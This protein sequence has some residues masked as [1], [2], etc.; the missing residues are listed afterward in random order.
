MKK[1]PGEGPIKA[2]YAVV[3]EAPGGDEEA[4]GR[5][6]VGPAGRLLDALLRNAGI[7]RA[8]CWVTNVCKY[9]PPENKIEKWI[10]KRKKPKKGDTTLVAERAGRWYTAQVAEGLFEL[11]REL[12]E[13]QPEKIIAFGNAALWALTGEWGIGNWRGSE[14]EYEGV[15]ARP[16]IP[17]YHPAAVLRQMDLKFEVQHDL[18]A[19][20]MKASHAPPRWKFETELAPDEI[21]ARL[22]ALPEVVAVDCEMSH[23]DIILIQIATSPCDAFCVQF[24]D[25]NGKPFWPREAETDLK[26]ALARTLRERFI[27]GQNFVMWDSW[28]IANC[29]GEEVAC[30]FDTQVAQHVLM[31]GK[32]K[33]L[34]YLSS[35]YCG[36]HRYWKDDLKEWKETKVSATMRHY[37]CEDAV[38]TYEVYLKQREVLERRQMTALFEERMRFAHSCLAV[39]R[40]GLLMSPA[41][42]AAV[43][44]VASTKISELDTVV[45]TKAGREVNVRSA[46]QVSQL[47]YK[48]LALP[49]GYTRKGKETTGDEALTKLARKFPEHRELLEAIY[50][51][52]SLASLGG[53]YVRSKANGEG[54][55]LRK[56]PDAD[57]RIRTSLNPAGPE[58]YR[59]SSGENPWGGGTNF[60][61]LTN[62]DDAFLPNVRRCF[63]PDDGYEIAEADLQRADLQIVVWEADDADLK[64]KL[65][66]GVDI[67]EENARDLG[68]PAAPGSTVRQTNKSFIHG[69]NYGLTPR[70]AAIEFGMTV[71][72][73]EEGQRRW[74]GMHPSIREWQHRV[75][76]ELKGRKTVTNAFGYRRTWYGR[77][78]H[79]AVK[80][81]LAWIGQST[82][83][84]AIMRAQLQFDA[85]PEALA[86]VELLLQNHDSLLFQW[87]IGFTPARLAALHETLLVPVPFADPLTIDYDLKTS[88]VSWGDCEKRAW[89]LR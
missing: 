26:R 88:R 67:H 8:D 1:V 13:R 2:R 35:L 44:A 76:A 30:D 65:R 73:A 19:R 27:I 43:L 62:G 38:R 71:H 29:W 68:L 51:I 81:A 84:I 78:D 80:E 15:I 10:V 59:L 63:V 82:V 89:P 24:F 46:P 79:S 25:E 83:A 70:T 34:A 87:P 66:A 60:Q 58:T 21:L 53:T 85:R 56:R 20:V 31:A 14:M 16:L 41:T 49:Q 77:I 57:G 61:N 40:R 86:E 47:L 18:R 74:F 22:A 48:D 3:G 12:Y 23:R 32:P 4:L 75:E 72:Q 42:T 69:T 17:T 39:S 55:F 54:G 45:L 36:W 52:R 64:A 7:D 33:D 5:P 50:G 28:Y 9:R 11:G 6:F 37:G